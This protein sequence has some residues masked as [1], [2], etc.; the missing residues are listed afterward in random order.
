[1]EQKQTEKQKNP[2][3]KGKLRLIWRFLSRCK[4]FFLLSMLLAVVVSLLE[5]INPQIISFTVDSVIGDEPSTLTGPAAALVEALGGAGSL[6]AKL[7]LVALAVLIMSVAALIFRYLFKLLNSMAAERLVLN[8]REML[9]SHI[10]RLPFE[11]HGKNQTGDIIQRC[12]SDVDTV[13]RFLSEQLTSVFRI[14]TLIALSLA[15]MYP[16]NRVLFYIA[17]ASIPIII[18]YSGIFHKYISR[19]FEACDEAEGVLSA[20]TQENLTG[21]RVV[22]AFGREAYERERFKKQS[23]LYADLWIKLSRLFSLFWGTGD[24]ISGIQVML[25]IT[26]GTVICVNGDMT[27]G[28]FIAFISY[29]AMLVWPVRQLGRMISQM[30]QAGIALDRI[31]YIMNSKPEADKPVTVPGNMSGDIVFENVSFNY[32]GGAPVLDGVS[33]TIKRGTTFGILGSTGSGKSTLMYLLDRLYELPPECGRI[34]VGGVDIADMK[35]E[36][37]RSGIGMVMQEPFLFSRT[38]AENIAVTFDTV[39]DGAVREAARVACLD[40]AVESFTEGYDTMV[41]ER[42]VTLSGGQKQRTAIAR[43]LTRRT[44]I[45]VFDD[46]LSAVDAETDV[47][48]RRALREKTSDATVIL[49]SHRTSTLM[50]A[51]SILVL[52]RGRVVDIGTHDELISREGLYRRIYDIQMQTKEACEDDC[53]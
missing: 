9:F 29:N 28:N 4:H 5:L 10:E 1:M 18:L 34:T 44:P 11:W 49:I 42:G 38:I 51:D 14:V 15:F 3:Q 50:Q 12:T 40:E 17:L 39:D 24:L 33:F 37:V 26:V 23:G 8:M 25:I 7:W 45:M 47:K 16:M 19:N 48:I 30:S 20:I 21:V 52:D 31:A 41:G 27:V 2:R 32:G 36:E 35:A 46:S 13:K 22:R 53:E 6:G 43:M